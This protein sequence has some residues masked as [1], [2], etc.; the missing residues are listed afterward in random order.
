MAFSATLHASGH[1]VK[2]NITLSVPASSSPRLAVRRT[3]NGS[4][5]PLRLSRGVYSL[6]TTG[7]DQFFR[8]D[9]PLDGYSGAVS[10]DLLDLEP[11]QNTPIA[12]TY[13]Y[14]YTVSGTPTVQTA[15]VA[16]SG[17]VSRGGDFLY[18]LSAMAR[19]TVVN[20]LSFGDLTYPTRGSRDFA[21]GARS[22]LIGGDLRTLPSAKIVLG[23]FTNADAEVLRAILFGNAP[24]ALS[25]ANP[26]YGFDGPFY[27]DAGDVVE[28]RGTNLGIEPTRIWEI[29][30]QQI[31]AP[32]PNYG[33]PSAIPALSSSW[34]TFFAGY[35]PDT[36]AVASG[37]YALGMAGSGAA[38]D[39]DLYGT[40]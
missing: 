28:R 34:A 33:T 2:L 25:P 15:T 37:E 22:P 36:Y 8:S 13:T 19:G 4:A 20:V 12:Y 14:S 39:P 26:N 11:P 38:Y 35:T 3:A 16:L 17:T 7:V 32:V 27:F 40:G 30:A 23:T 21:M 18:D 9:M 5:T 24:L 6:N 1:I 29:D 31:E 10:I